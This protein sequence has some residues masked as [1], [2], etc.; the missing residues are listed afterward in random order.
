MPARAAELMTSH[1]VTVE[2]DDTLT[3][4]REIFRNRPFHHLLVVEDG[5]L[6]G[7][8]S[9]GDLQRAI[10]HRI[11]TPNETAHDRASLN[12]RVHQVM[13]RQPVTLAPD[14]ELHEIVHAFGVHRFSIFPI[15]DEKGRLLG[16]LS[17]RDVF[18]ALDTALWEHGQCVLCG[19]PHTSAHSEPERT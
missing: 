18:G 15:V 11:D 3:T 8:L 14:A 19:Q 1:P 9:N 2:M 17:W 16:V 12:R 6:M 10:S 13:S 7:V 4:V 5:K